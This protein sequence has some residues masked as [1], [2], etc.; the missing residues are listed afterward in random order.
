MDG[1]YVIF[2]LVEHHLSFFFYFYI[3]LVWNCMSS[4]GSEMRP[5]EINGIQLYPWDPNVYT[6]FPFT[7]SCWD[8]DGKKEK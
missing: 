7:S 4:T 2:I 3:L 1:V 5:Q 8:P 6:S